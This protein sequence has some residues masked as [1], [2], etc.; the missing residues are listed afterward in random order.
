M[1]VMM[2]RIIRKNRSLTV[3]YLLL[4]DTAAIV[5]LCSVQT[6]I[7]VPPQILQS[8]WGPIRMGVITRRN[9]EVVYKLRYK[10]VFPPSVCMY[11]VFR[12]CF[13]FL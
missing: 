9:F 1:K 4:E 13:Q 10:L 6:Q 12:I 7:A 3:E 11:L 2:K 8:T 5:H